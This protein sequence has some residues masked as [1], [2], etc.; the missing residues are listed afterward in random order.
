TEKGAGA[1]LDRVAPESPGVPG[2][3]EIAV[4]GPVAVRHAMQS[5]IQ[6]DLLRAGLIALP[7]TLALLVMVFG[8]A[9]AALLPLGV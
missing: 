3:V 9:V 1:I 6:E 5:I 4:G 2:P 8:S 7:V